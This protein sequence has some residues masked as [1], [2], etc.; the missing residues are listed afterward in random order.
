[1]P[2]FII[3][4][5]ILFSLHICEKKEEASIFEVNANIS[6]EKEF[7]VQAGQEFII[8]LYSSTTSLVLLN[9]NEKD[10]VSFIKT[11]YELEYDK[12]K[13]QQLL[14]DEK[15][16]ILYFFKAN[17]ITEEP[18]LLKFADAYSYLKESNPVPKL[19]IKINVN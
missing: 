4:F 15:G 6:K 1:M 19:I 13:Q 3:Y 16:Y 9:K 5:I 10:S 12:K 14:R 7:T 17:A 8:K 18:K 2:K 11:E